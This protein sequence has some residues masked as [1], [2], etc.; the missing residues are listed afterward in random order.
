VLGS[1]GERIGEILQV[2]RQLFNGKKTEPGRSRKGD[3]RALVG[4]NVKDSATGVRELNKNQVLK[5]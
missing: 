4:I 2:H 3:R 1:N 5:P